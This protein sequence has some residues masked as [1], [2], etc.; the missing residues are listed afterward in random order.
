M[1]CNFWVLFCAL[2]IFVSLAC[3]MSLP[4]PVI[5]S[6]KTLSISPTPASL[7][8]QSS[9]TVEKHKLAESKTGAEF[10][11]SAN[12]AFDR[13]VTADQA[14]WLRTK[15]WPDAP[16]AI[17]S[18]LAK[19]TRLHIYLSPYGAKDWLEVWVPELGVGGYVNGDYVGN[20]VK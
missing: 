14:L 13:C 5:R 7:P 10:D 20:C 3:T 4:T 2:A 15:P 12:S 11:V 19:G 1:K 9:V 17:P 16:L 8:T 6:E 18:A